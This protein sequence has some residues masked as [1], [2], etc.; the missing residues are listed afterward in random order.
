MLVIEMND[1]KVMKF[2]LDPENA[3]ITCANMEKLANEGF[4]DGLIFHRIIKDFMIQGGDPEGTGIGGSDEEIKG[5][6]IGNGVVNNH[7]HKRGT[8]SM[9][10]AQDPNSASSQFF[11]CHVDTPFLDG[12]YAAFGDMVEGFEV[13]DELAS[14][15]T[16]FNDRPVNPPV[17]K[18]IY[19][20]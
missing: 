15:K 7:K 11:I 17:I 5:E 10:R 4:Y 3:P 20:K 18:T 13:L 12:Q 2:E 8:I 19:V 1:G 6:F 16:S 9:A 14:V